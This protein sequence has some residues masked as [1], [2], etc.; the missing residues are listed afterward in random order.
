MSERKD[1]PEDLL[2]TADRLPSIGLVAAMRFAGVNRKV[3]IVSLHAVSRS[4]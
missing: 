4:A 2:G 1:L 3:Q